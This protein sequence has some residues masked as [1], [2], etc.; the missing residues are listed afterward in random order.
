MVLR[1]VGRMLKECIRDSDLLCRYGGEEFAV[2]LTNIQPQEAIVV[3]ER[4]RQMVAVHRFEH[5]SSRFHITASVGI[6]S[7]SSAT[8]S[9]MELLEVA[10]QALYQAKAG[11]RNKVVLHTHGMRWHRPKL[12]KVLVSEGYV[13]EGELNEALSEQRLRLGEILVQ[14][15]LITAQQL[16]RA[17]DCQKKVSERLGQILKRLGHS[18]DEDIH[19]ALNRMKRKLGEILSEKGL[20]TADELRW[21][22]AGQHHEP[23]QIQ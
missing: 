21:A 1:E 5:N 22:L 17:L 7:F 11:G 15:G 13:T 16:D 19:W 3:C 9:P 14:G 4:F 23:G 8:E 12:G 2:I 6:A 20:L 10:D 18:T